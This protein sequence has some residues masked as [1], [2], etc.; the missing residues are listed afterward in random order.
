MNWVSL[1]I[2]SV[3]CEFVARWLDIGLLHK[4]LPVQIPLILLTFAIQ[5]IQQS[6]FRGKKATTAEILNV[7]FM[8]KKLPCI[9]MTNLKHAAPV[10]FVDWS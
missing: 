1:E 6:S 2:V 10:P 8:N 9:N 4:K 5:W 3:T 7:A